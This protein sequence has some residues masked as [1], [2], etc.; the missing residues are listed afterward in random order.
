[1]NGAGRTTWDRVLPFGVPIGS[2][3][4]Y[5]I[6]HL[7]SHKRGHILDKMGPTLAS[8]AVGYL[9]P[10]LISDELLLKK[11]ARVRDADLTIEE[12]TIPVAEFRRLNRTLVGTFCICALLW[13]TSVMFTYTSSITWEWWGIVTSLVSGIVS[14][15]IVYNFHESYMT[16]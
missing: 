3:L 11:W 16:S 13:I 5:S 9:F 14:Y 15:A 4:F 6:L 8:F 12:A 1:V 2:I 10:L 7:A